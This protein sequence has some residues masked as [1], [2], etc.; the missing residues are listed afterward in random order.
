MD[1]YRTTEAP[2]EGE[3]SGLDALATAVCQVGG[4]IPNRDRGLPGSCG[5]HRRMAWAYVRIVEAA[6]VSI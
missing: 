5:F 3:H 6:Q 2:P 4:H 1:D